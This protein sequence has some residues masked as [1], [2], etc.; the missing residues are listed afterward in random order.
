MLADIGSLG[1]GGLAGFQRDRDVRRSVRREAGDRLLAAVVDLGI[2]VAGNGNSNFVALE[3]YLQHERA[4]RGDGAGEDVV[5]VGRVKG[6]AVFLRGHVV[7][8]DRDFRAGRALAHLVR[9]GLF[10]SEGVVRLLVVILNG[11]LRS[12]RPLG[13][14]DVAVLLVHAGVCTR[15]KGRATAVR[16]GV[17]AGEL[18]VQTGEAQFLR[19]LH[20]DL[21]VVHERRERLGRSR[22]AVRVVGQLDGLFFVAVHGVERRALR[23]DGQLIVGLIGDVGAALFGRPAE[24]HLVVRGRVVLGLLHVRLRAGCVVLAIGEGGVALNVR[25]R[26]LSSVGEIRI[27]SNISVGNGIKVKRDIRVADLFRPADKY[28]VA[29][30]IGRRQLIFRREL[31][32]V[33]FL[34]VADCKRAEFCIVSYGDIG[35]SFYRRLFPFGVDKNIIRR[36]RLA[37]KIIRSRCG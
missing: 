27:E 18:I 26:D 9:S 10:L 16:S 2:A 3:V 29:A 23:R 11:I 12:R 15:R 22:A 37:V 28:P 14:E 21:A 6:V 30:I 5:F 35:S 34:S 20:R 33:D 1:D 31:A 17:P 7:A 4:V 8:G 19:R 13:I 25:H 24:E 36:H 32:L